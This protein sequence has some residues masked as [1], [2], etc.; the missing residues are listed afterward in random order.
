MS[1]I[2][3]TSLAAATTVGIRNEVINFA[4]SILTR[5]IVLIGVADATKLSSG[6]S[7][8]T[9]V[10]VFS[11]GE[12]GAIA[13]TGT[14][15][16]RL[17]IASEKSSQGVE[18][19]IIPQAEGGS[20]VASTGDITVTASS[21]ESGTIALYINGQSV[22]VTVPSGSDATSIGD[23]IV[24]A[25]GNDSSLPVSA[26]N[27]LGVVTLTSISKGVWGNEI[28]ITTN[29]SN[30]RDV[31][32]V[33]LAI[34]DMSG[35]AGSADITLALTAMGIGDNA[36]EYGFTAVQHGYGVDQ[37]T[38]NALSTYNGEGN[39]TIGCYD[40]I[41]G[42]FFRSLNGSVANDLSAEITVSDVRTLDRTNGVL[43]IPNSPNH[44]SEF[45]ATAMA[46]MEFINSQR[47][48][49]SY[50][51]IVLPGVFP[52]ATRWSDEYD[53]RDLAV[54][55]G[56][57]PTFI[58]SGSVV[59]QNVVTYY[60]PDYVPAANNGYRSMRNISL[61]QNVVY[62][63]R[64]YFEQEEWQNITIVKDVARVTNPKIA[65][66]AKDV[67]V[68]KN[69]LLYLGGLFE[70][71]GMIFSLD[72]VIAGL[73]KQNSVVVRLSGSGFDY[74][75]ELVY[76]GEGGLLNGDVIFDINFG[77]N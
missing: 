77:V 73:A 65:R 12:V 74:T 20:D 35:G 59:L 1:N 33:T 31:T 53:A 27:A 8:D 46:S 69:A 39:S 11:A 25:I 75:L 43:V 40:P 6:L 15:I 13:G 44:P 32:G 66:R 4:E 76:S 2:T 47:A 62:I 23:L 71:N 24:S 57:S 45:S 49:G 54:K 64:N 70:G 21:V 30:E 42:R 26:V 55:N 67:Q 19:W 56:I 17:A 3:S 41:N 34:T 16:H 48:N 36:N 38:L 22:N 50:F 7:V 14:M 68:V 18:T 37:I 10:R 9:P 5:K 63:V 61:S 60:R 58:K 51:N 28:S 72:S 29:L 52:G